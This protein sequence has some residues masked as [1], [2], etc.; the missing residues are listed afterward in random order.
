[1]ARRGFPPR[2]RRCDDC[3][4]IYMQKAAKQVR[5]EECQKKH[6]AKRVKEREDLK[7]KK[8]DYKA[9]KIKHDPNVCNKVKKCEYGTLCGGTWICDYREIEGRKRPC[10]VKGCTEFRRKQSGK[11]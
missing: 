2:P 6:L 4:Q 9:W 7:L 3:G 11:H 1:M 5:C 10:P 8:T